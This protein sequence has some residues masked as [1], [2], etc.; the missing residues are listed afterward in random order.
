[1]GLLLSNIDRYLLACIPK[2]ILIQNLRF[3]IYQVAER[4]ETLLWIVYVVLNPLSDNLQSIIKLFCIWGSLMEETLLRKSVRVTLLKRLISPIK[5]FSS[6]CSIEIGDWP[7][8]I[9][10]LN[11]KIKIFLQKSSCV[12]IYFEELLRFTS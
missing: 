12:I 10:I 4:L 8:K 7:F 6:N 2:L 3:F 9:T 11:V 1:M 5:H